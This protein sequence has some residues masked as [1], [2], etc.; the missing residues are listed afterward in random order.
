[1]PPS[2]TRQAARG[3]DLGSPAQAD[4]VDPSGSPSFSSSLVALLDPSVQPSVVVVDVLAVVHANET[5]VT[6][7][8]ADGKV[9]AG[10]VGCSVFGGQRSRRSHRFACL[11]TPSERCSDPRLSEIREPRSVR[12][13]AQEPLLKALQTS[14][15]SGLRAKTYKKEGSH[16]RGGDLMTLLSWL[17][18]DAP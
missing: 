5:D 14:P 4:G 1:M 2:R 8:G 11:T 7:H 13:P 6:V 16:G 15:W 18:S 9:T 17:G 12:R 3:V 10:T